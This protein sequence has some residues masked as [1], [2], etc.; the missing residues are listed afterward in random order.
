MTR[1]RASAQLRLCRPAFAIQHSPVLHPFG[2]TTHVFRDSGGP[3]HVR[4]RLPGMAGRTVQL[5]FE[6]TQDESFTCVNVRPGHTC[7]V[8]VDN[9]VMN[10]VVSTVPADFDR[11]RDVDSPDYAALRPCL[12]GPS[13]ARTPG[14]A[15]KDLNNDGHIDLLDF[16][17][18][19]RAFSP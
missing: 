16:A 2:T 13:V 17:R 18:F 8:Q 7:G 4:M 11:D 6:Y 12:Q 10:S 19:Q 3:K 1:L 9:I 14:C 5:R 15:P